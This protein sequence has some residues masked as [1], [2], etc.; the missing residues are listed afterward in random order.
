[1]IA[2]YKNLHVENSEIGPSELLVLLKVDE[3]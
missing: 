1:M 2:I 3:I